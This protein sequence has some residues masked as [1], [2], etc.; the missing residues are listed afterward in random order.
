[1]SDSSVILTFIRH[2]EST[3]NLR[4]IWA[5]WKDAPLSNHGMNVRCARERR[6]RQQP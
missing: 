4:S 3:D 5:G 2:G 6:P 1:M